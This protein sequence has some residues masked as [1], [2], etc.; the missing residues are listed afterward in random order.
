MSLIA[1]ISVKYL[2]YPKR[3]MLCI[4]PG[5]SIPWGNESEIFMI[6]ILGGKVSFFAIL[7]GEEIFLAF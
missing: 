2:D 6:A 3:C 1:T 4:Y 7:E 5:A